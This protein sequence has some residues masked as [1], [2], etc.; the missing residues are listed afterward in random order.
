[1]SMEAFLIVVV[2]GLV[3]AAAML[4]LTSSPA[5]RRMI[6]DSRDRQAMA[7]RE[8]ARARQTRADRPFGTADLRSE[9]DAVIG[10][11]RRGRRFARSDAEETAPE[12]E[13]TAR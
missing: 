7:D 13:R 3:L 6:D 10:G 5:R 9:R 2:V 11:E 1:M 12:P 8:V 4:Y